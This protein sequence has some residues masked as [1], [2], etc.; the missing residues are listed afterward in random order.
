VASQNNQTLGRL[1]AIGDIHGHSLAL[2]SLIRLINPGSQ[3]VVVTLGDYVNRGPDSSGVLETLLELQTQCRL[4]PILG[5]HDEIML[6][7]R[8]DRHAEGR[9]MYQG[10][11]ATLRSYG[12]DKSIKNVPESHW[13]FIAKCLPLYSMESFLFVHANY[14]W[15]SGLADQPPALLRWLSLNESIPQPHISGKTVILGH[16]LGPLRDL[17]FCRCIDTGCGFGGR[18]TAIDVNSNECWQVTETGEVVDTEP[19]IESV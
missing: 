19:W 13:E 1:I 16:T 6:D 9:W 12:V 3:D 15:H 17:G 4:I 14:C 7:S 18:L 11:E 10:G 2:R 5:N 8:N